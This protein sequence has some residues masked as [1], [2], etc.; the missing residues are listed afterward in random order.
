MVAGPQHHL[1]LRDAVGRGRREADQRVRGEVGGGGEAGGPECGGR[2]YEGAGGGHPLPTRDAIDGRLH[3]HGSWGEQAR[4]PCIEG[5]REE[6]Q[7]GIRSGVQKSSRVPPVR[8][9]EGG[10]SEGDGRDD[11]DSGGCAEEG[12]ARVA[13]CRDWAL[14]PL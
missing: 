5:V 7:Q 10:A 11:E 4:G 9:N 3:E 6:E 8:E 2:G 1:R 13:S 12:G 14:A